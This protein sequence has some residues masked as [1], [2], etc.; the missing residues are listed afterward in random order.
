MQYVLKISGYK[1]ARI[2]QSKASKIICRS[3]TAL[4]FY[5]NMIYQNSLDESEYYH[6]N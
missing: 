1:Q 4:R 3:A 5:H 6:A 2:S